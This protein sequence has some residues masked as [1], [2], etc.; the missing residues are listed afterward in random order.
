[1]GVP[2]RSCLAASEKPLMANLLAQYFFVMCVC[3]CVMCVSVRFCV[4]CVSN[5]WCHICTIEPV[6]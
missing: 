3:V 1:M 5:V 4:M 6:V 2:N